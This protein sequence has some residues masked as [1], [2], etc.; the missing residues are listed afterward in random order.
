[1][2]IKTIHAPIP[3]IFYRRPA[4]DQPPFKSDGD[5][6]AQGETIGLIEVMK[7]YTPVVAEEPGRIVRFIVENEE[8]IMAGQGLVEIDG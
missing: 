1:M 3:G 8:P 6:V 4:P 7:T 5:A 2:A